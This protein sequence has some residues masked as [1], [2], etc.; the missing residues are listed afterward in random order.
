MIDR[1]PRQTSSMTAG[2]TRQAT[3]N[4]SPLLIVMAAPATML[5]A[6]IVITVKH[7]APINRARERSFNI[8][9][10]LF[11]FCYEDEERSGSE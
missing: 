6:P 2:G 1:A 5:H 4:N 10:V 9:C 11:R 3:N 7:H 8:A